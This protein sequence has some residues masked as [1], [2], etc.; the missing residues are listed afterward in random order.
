MNVGVV[1]EGVGLES[2]KY[3]FAGIN[4]SLAKRHKVTHRPM[5]CFYCSPCRQ[6]ELHEEFVGSSD[7][8]VGVLDE[9]ILRTRE[10]LD[11]RP[12]L[13]AFLCGAMSR[14]AAGVLPRV[15][16][17][18]KSTDVLVG[19]CSGDVEITRK[20]FKNGQVRNLPFSFDE[21]TFY[22]MEDA[23]RRA[24]KAEL[25]FKENDRILLYAGRVTLEK[26]LHTQLRML[27]VLQRLLPN[28]H[29]VIIGDVDNIPFY[30]FGVY[31]A[32]M[33]GL[34]TRLLSDL[35]LDM[36]RIH[37]L[38]H[39]NPRQTRDYYV[40]ADAV[41]NLTQH[42][43]E[44]FGLAQ[45]EAMACGT[46]VIGTA[47]GG[48][49]D[50]IKHGET[51]YHISTV[52][53]NSGVK[54]NWWE[55]LNRIV[56]LLGDDATLRRF[57][58]HC[59]AH[60]RKHFSKQGYDEVLESILVD[61]MRA[62]EHRSEPLALSEFG[63]EFWHCCRH[64]PMC[65]PPYQRSQRS[66]ALYQEL[67]APFTGVTESTVAAT[68]KLHADHL[69]VLATP[70]HSEGRQ[71]KLN[72]PIYPLEVTVPAAYE[73]A[74][75]GILEVVRREPVVQLDYL[76]SCLDSSLRTSFEGTLRWMLNAGILLRT[77]PMNP[78]INPKA[79]DEQMSKPRFA[80]QGVDYRTDVFVVK[81]CAERARVATR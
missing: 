74:C 45:V 59:P 41:V 81:Q 30:E 8:L 37:F 69:L 14:G 57:R 1:A 67:I 4:E 42:H 64:Q 11:H 21:S 15:H 26:N 23:E 25:G 43:D 72:D 12:P 3:H 53:T 46:P 75:H 77:R 31:A 19:N 79:I 51:G 2:M 78:S 32:D 28:L 44:N 70:V 10:R 40:I 71:L 9:G 55:A 58:Q 20:F 5:E 35:R 34:L 24:L 17:Y 61:C 39:K 18:L 13:V 52:V 38:G 73:P 49:K 54:P 60:I 76:R 22:P 6:E 56:Q 62:S 63:A 48:L 47:W 33:S 29:F 27:T 80:I 7:V 36:N 50:S 16:R 68:E 66:L 65:P